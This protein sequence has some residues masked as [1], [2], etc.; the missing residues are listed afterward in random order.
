MFF[1]TIFGGCSGSHSGSIATASNVAG[2]SDGDQKHHAPVRVKLKFSRVSHGSN[3]VASQSWLIQAYDQ[4][5]YIIESCPRFHEATFVDSAVRTGFVL[6]KA[7]DMGTIQGR[8]FP[9]Y[10]FRS[11]DVF[12]DVVVGWSEECDR[13]ELRLQ[14]SPDH[15]PREWTIPFAG[16]GTIELITRESSMG[17]SSDGLFV[18]DPKYP[19]GYE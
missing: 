12:G 19:K 16:Q 18:V 17:L 13:V 3:E 4:Q 15:R 2:T 7:R 10:R 8:E 6:E 14:Y 1:T 5:S 9:I 11:K